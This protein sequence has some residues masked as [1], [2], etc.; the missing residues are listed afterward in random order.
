MKVNKK[1]IGITIIFIWAVIT[2]LRVFYHQPWYDEAHAYVLA[3]N[4][5]IPELIAEMK[6]EGHLLI[7]YLLIMPFAKL[8][9]YYP[10]PMQIINWL[11]AFGAILIMWKKAPLHP[12]TK[13][14]ITFSYPFLAELPVVARCY[15][16]G[17]LFLFL[18]A[19]LYSKST[20]HPIWYS[21]FI[22]LC[23][24][25]SVMALFGTTAFGLI[26]AYDLIKGAL[27]DEVKRKDFI[28]SF[29]IM[30]LT[31]VLILLQI[32][33]SVFV[34]VPMEY[35]LSFYNNFSSFVYD[36]TN[37]GTLLILWYKFVVTLVSIFM[38]IILFLKNK[39]LFFIGLFTVSCM[40]YCFLFKYSGFSQHLQFF[41]I[42]ALILCWLLLNEEKNRSKLTVFA[43]VLLALFF[44]ILIFSTQIKNQIVYNSHSKLVYQLIEKTVDPNSRIIIH[45]SVEEEIVPYFENSNIE[46]YLY[47]IA[48]L[49]KNSK[50]MH[51]II[52]NPVGVASAPYISP[53]WLE[54]SVSKDKKTYLL[55]QYIPNHDTITFSDHKQFISAKKYMVFSKHHTLYEV[56]ELNKEIDK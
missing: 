19:S 22:L 6:D 28:I 16:V 53:V 56:G 34:R 15:S 23:A 31:A 17:V 10:Y 45:N 11:C 30:A 49:A 18:I 35:A 55:T 36:Y 20:K 41:W 44:S 32:G 48:D 40:M 24:N 14:I 47:S 26:F 37:N 13:T 25:T 42:Y 27:K 5:S 21:V 46:I 7:W 39:K 8:K 29:S 50:T 43:E 1:F 4:L 2:L 54:K 3:Q 9:L 38:F 51:N 12:V 52:L 33:G